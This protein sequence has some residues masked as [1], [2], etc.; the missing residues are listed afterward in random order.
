MAAKMVRARPIIAVDIV[1]SRLEL[2]LELGATFTVNSREEKIGE[3]LRHFAG[4]IDHA[5]D[6]TGLSRIIDQGIRS[7]GGRG[8]MSLIGIPAD[9]P[10]ERISPKSPGPDQ[11]VFYSI[12]GDSD[13]QK[14]I[15]FM[16]KSFKEGKFPYDKMIRQYPADR[17]NQAVEDVL[18][19]V[20]V[21]PLLRF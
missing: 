8:K 10:G 21:K 13:P 16:I 6:T 11:N 14:F 20:T 17:I 5:V 15:P 12:A 19:G 3:R 4:R 9:P 2:A 18:S 7:L 1:P